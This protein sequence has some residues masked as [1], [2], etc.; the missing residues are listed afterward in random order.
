MLLSNFF[1][2]FIIQFQNTS[3]LEAIAVISSLVYLYLATKENKWCFLFGLISSIIY[4]YICFEIKLYFDTFINFYYV[5][6]SFVGFLSWN[7]TKKDS[8]ANI[9]KISLSKFTIF[10]S[11]G[12]LISLGLGFYA[13][14]YTDAAF[15]FIDAFTTIFALIATWMVIKKYLENWIIWIVVDGIS[16]ALYYQK[17]LVFTSFL[18]LIYTIIAIQGFYKWKRQLN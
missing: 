14:K 5:I 9:N 6:M 13:N 1:S 15:P 7:K 2:D 11:I 16:I 10:S 8:P 4:V 12:L 3:F 18:F 17:S